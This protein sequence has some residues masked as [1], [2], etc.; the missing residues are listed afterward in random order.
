MGRQ[1]TL[2]RFVAYV[3][4]PHG[5]LAAPSLHSNPGGHAR[6]VSL[7][8]YCPALQGRHASLPGPVSAFGHGYLSLPLGHAK[9]RGQSRQGPLISSTY[10]PVPLKPHGRHTAEPLF[11][12]LLPHSTGAA[13]PPS[14][15][16]PA[17]HTAHGDALISS[18]VS[19]GGQYTQSEAFFLMVA[20][21]AASHSRQPSPPYPGKHSHSCGPPA[22]PP[23]AEHIPAVRP[24]KAQS[25]SLGPTGALGRRHHPLRHTLIY[26]SVF[27]MTRS[28]SLPFPSTS[29][30][31]GAA[32]RLTSIDSNGL[33]APV[34]SAGHVL[35]P[36]FKKTLIFPS[37]F[38]T[39]RSSH[40][41]LF[42][43][44]S[45]GIASS[46]T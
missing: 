22:P 14:H 9:P 2:L 17:A 44:T 45:V 43:S 39:T 24:P 41:S 4:L 31:V 37:R 16:Y 34:A 19:P 36:L 38:P 15:A 21:Y 28:S 23:T 32:S 42:T 12:A 27:P 40:P 18:F 29:A 1:T 6:H 5:V 13:S 10:C 35:V 3:W 11:V 46:P 20:P 7:A 8:R 30:N 25:F 33:A 26:P